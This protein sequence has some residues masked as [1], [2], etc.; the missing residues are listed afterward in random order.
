MNAQQ[1]PHWPAA[2]AWLL[3]SLVAALLFLAALHTDALS[4]TRVLQFAAAM[5]TLFGFGFLLA[6]RFPDSSLV[7]RYLVWAARRATRWYNVDELSGVVTGG[8][9]GAAGWL[10]LAIAGILAVVSL[11]V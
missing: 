6:A 1:P 9:A 4:E 5:M 3:A 10:C 7:Y 2:A 11:W 8:K